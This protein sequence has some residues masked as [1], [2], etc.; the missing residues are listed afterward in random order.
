MISFLAVI[1]KL[2]T[3]LDRW[4]ALQ[5]EKKAQ[6]EYDELEANPADWFDNHFSGLSDESSKAESTKA[7]ASD[8]K[9]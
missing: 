7:N 9:A 1:D 5:K 4:V 6:K 3:F 2:L 8:K